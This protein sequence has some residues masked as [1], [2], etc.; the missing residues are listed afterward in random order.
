MAGLRMKTR[1]YKERERPLDELAS[2]LAFII[3]KIGATSLLELE[4]EGFMTYS[5]KDRLLVMAEFLAFLL[6]CSDRL[7]YENK[8]EDADRDAF[9]SALGKHLLRAYTDNQRELYGPADYD[10]PFLNFINRRIEDYSE[11]N[12]SDGEPRVDFLRYFG[13][14]VEAVLGGPQKHWVSQHIMELEAP[15][16]VKQLKKAMR[17]LFE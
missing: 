3:W 4:N 1:W 12:F 16:A 6:Q 5:N 17:D 15:N 14:Q 13:E 9:I 8:M 2:A 11:L 10:T 7:A